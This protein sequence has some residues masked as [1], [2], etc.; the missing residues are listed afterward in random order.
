L[1]TEAASEL[2]DLVA[3][4]TIAATLGCHGSLP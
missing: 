4:K 1:F 2:F 3:G